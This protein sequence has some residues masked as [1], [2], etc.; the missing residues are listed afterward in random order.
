MGVGRVG[1]E[2]V[3]SEGDDVLGISSR[4]VRLWH[5]EVLSHDV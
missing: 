2:W 4:K 3:A 1:L 5:Q